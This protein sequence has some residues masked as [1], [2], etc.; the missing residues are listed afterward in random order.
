MTI[1]ILTGLSVAGTV[2]ESSNFLIRLDKN[3]L[4]VDL[5]ISVTLGITAEE[6]KR[7][8]TR[9]FMDEVSLFIS[10]ESPLLVVA[11]P[12]TIFWRFPIVFSMGHYGK[13]GQV[14]Q[15]DVDAQGGELLLNDRLLEEIK[16]NA[17]TLARGAT[18]ST[19]N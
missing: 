17:R 7:K 6:A 5:N 16:A 18:L 1:A 2:R 14:G 4:Q 10:P 8:L 9:F 11:D 15:V 13:L 12:E 19:N 3:K